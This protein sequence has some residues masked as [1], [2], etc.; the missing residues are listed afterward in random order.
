M[1]SRSHLCLL[2]LLCLASRAAALRI[3]VFGGSGFIGSRVCEI[4]SRANCQVVAVSRSGGPPSWAM[5]DAWSTRVD[6][7]AADATTMSGEELGAIDAAVSCVGN[8]RPSPDWDGFWGLHWD[9]E[10]MRCE[11]GEINECIVN[12]SRSAGARRFVYISVSYDTAKAFEGPMP[13]YLDGKRTA[14]RSACTA[15]GQ[16]SLVIGPSLV[17]GGGRGGEFLIPLLSSPPIMAYQKLLSGL[18]SLSSSAYTDYLTRVAL[19]PPSTVDEVARCVA[20]GAV[21]SIDASSF[22]PRQQG[23]FDTNGCPASVADLPYVDGTKE[24]R[25]IANEFGTSEALADVVLAHGNSGGGANSGDS[26]E[27]TVSSATERMASA[28]P[29]LEGLLVGCRPYFY[30]L[31]VAAFFGGLFAWIVT[32]QEARLAGLH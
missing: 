25:R 26:R 9:D 11:N 32:L 19:A 17:V 13:G 24:I 15:F 27:V 22:G 1:A 20:A 21:G 31:P 23:F 16:N 5:S 6:W 18:Q 30:P 7:L 4:L 28:S 10:A 8:V 12:L 3:A 14:E 29:P 2:R